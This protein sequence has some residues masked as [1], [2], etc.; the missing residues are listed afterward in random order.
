MKALLASS[1]VAVTAASLL[2]A[3][4]SHAPAE[5]KLRPVRTVEVRYDG[6]RDTSRYFGSVRARY[7]V[8]QAFRVGGKVLERR[9]DVGQTVREGD[10]LAV[11][12]DVDYRLAEEA[13]T[14][15]ARRGH[16]ARAPGR[17]G[18]RGACEA[19]EGRWL[20]K[21]FRRGTRAERTAH[22]ARGCRGR[23]AQARTGAQSGEVHRTARVERR[24]R[25]E[26]AARGRTGR[27][28]GPAGHRDC[29]RG[30]AGDRRRRAGGAPGGLQERPLQR[31]A[32]ERAGRPVRGRRCANSRR[33]RPRRRARIAP[34]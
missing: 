4:G 23:D 27:R 30:R 28:R 7:E 24:R 11:L 29:E 16:R 2:V 14:P 8:E 10:V 18:L 32:R 22:L 26:R 33:R 17:V 3:C 31:V 13:V 20:G 21:R 19:S 15:A 5:E 9:V 34:A 12:D 25:D 6:A 1:A